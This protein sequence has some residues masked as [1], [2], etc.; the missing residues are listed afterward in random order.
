[1]GKCDG[2]TRGSVDSIDT[3][4]IRA[5]YIRGTD[6]RPSNERQTNQSTWPGTENPG[7]MGSKSGPIGGPQISDTSRELKTKQ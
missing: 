5:D 3:G 7:R 2:T 6:S 1:M 4:I